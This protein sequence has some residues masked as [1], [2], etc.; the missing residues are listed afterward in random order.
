MKTLVLIILFSGAILGERGDPEPSNKGNQAGMG[1]VPQQADL[2]ILKTVDPPESAIDE[3]VTFTLTAGNRGPDPATGVI[4]VDQLP[5]GYTFVS[6]SSDVGSYDPSSGQWVIGDLALGQLEQLQIEAQVTVWRHY[7]NTATISGDQDDPEDG[8]NSASA[9]P[10]I[11]PPPEAIIVDTLLDVVAEDGLCSLREAIINAQSLDQPVSTDCA[12]ARTVRFDESLIGGTIELNGSPLPTV[13]EELHLEG[14]VPGDPGGLTIDARGL[15]RI[16]DMN[17]SADFSIR[18]VTLTGGRTT[19]A[20]AHG[21]AIRMT[22]N[23]HAALERVR[24]EGNV[25]E[26]ASGGAIYSHDSVLIISDSEFSGNQVLSA[27]GSGGAIDVHVRDVTLSGSTLADNHSAGNGG[28]INLNR[29]TLNMV[30][31]TLSGN[32]AGGSGGA[33]N[34]DRST[35][36]LIHT[37]MAFNDA[38]GGGSGIHGLAT[39]D[40]PVELSLL[41]SLIVNNACNFSGG[42][43]TTVTV[44]GTQS[45]HPSC[46][47]VSPASLVSAAAI[48]LLP[49]ANYGG[50]TRTHGLDTGSSAI[51]FVPMCEVLY[52][53]NQDQRGAPRPGGYSRYCDVGA[54]EFNHGDGDTIFGSRFD[55]AAQ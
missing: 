53:V 51:D 13:V 17:N 40:Y 11:P 22:D 20:G 26:N 43:H 18:D 19:A 36:T 21:G 34:I 41:N 15:S 25:V 24:L 29:S 50:I 32:S 42:A 27:T 31:S 3:I 16:F 55:G 44:S 10:Y 45:T 33:I 38:S 49:L 47:P 4:V 28:G 23:T 14:P 46:L 8:N 9:E 5:S 39:A 6:A 52:G 54:F 7:L 35:A 48:R 12:F 37:T 2:E 1:V 30:N